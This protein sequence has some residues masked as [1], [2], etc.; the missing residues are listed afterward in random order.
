MAN[1]EYRKAKQEAE[2]VAKEMAILQRKYNKLQ[3][4]KQN[5]KEFKRDLH[6]AI[7]KDMQNAFIKVFEK[8]G[9]EKAIILLNLKAVREDILEKVPENDVEFDFASKNYYKILKQVQE[10]YVKDHN[11]K[12]IIEQQQEKKQN[13]V[14]NIICFITTLPFKVLKYILI[15][16]GMIFFNMKTK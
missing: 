4:E 9:T 11:A 3:E 13:G 2:K 15:F 6:I 16:F 10:I 12:R 1:L 5:E 14:F 7:E 8:Y